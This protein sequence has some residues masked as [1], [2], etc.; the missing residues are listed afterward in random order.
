[1]VGI[2]LAGW[3]SYFIGECMR[4]FKDAKLVYRLAF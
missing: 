2:V 1:M 4:I 3:K